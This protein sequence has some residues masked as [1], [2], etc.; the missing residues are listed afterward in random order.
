MWPWGHLAVGYLAYSIYVHARYREPPRDPAGALFLALG[1]QFPDLVDK[2]LGWAFG[3]LPSGTSLAHSLLVAPAVVALFWLLARGFGRS[4][5]GNAFGIGYLSHL[6][7]DALYPIMYG[8]SVAIEPFLWPLVVSEPS[9]M[10]GFLSNLRYYLSRYVEFVATP[11]GVGYVAF[12]GLLLGAAVWLWVYDGAP[13]TAILR[14]RL[15]R[16]TRSRQ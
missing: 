15:S 1:T 5:V 12:E 13:G 7:G 10:P 3:V 6:P 4:T 8:R 11:E 2:P 9:R 16:R 14:G